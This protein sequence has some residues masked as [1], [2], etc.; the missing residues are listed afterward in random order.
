ML[1]SG[2]VKGTTIGTLPVTL[3]CK[4]HVRTPNEDGDEMPS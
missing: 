2:V 4:R 1:E 3:L